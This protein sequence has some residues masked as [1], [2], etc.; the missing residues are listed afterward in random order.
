MYS[1]SVIFK[2]TSISKLTWFASALLFQFTA[3]LS[4]TELTI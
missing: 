2:Q 4:V 3:A 1:K